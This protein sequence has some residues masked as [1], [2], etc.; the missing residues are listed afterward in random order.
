MKEKM[1]M[2]RAGRNAAL[3]QE[4]EEK[5]YV[6]VG[7]TEIGDVSGIASKSELEKLHRE[8]YKDHKPGK[9]RLDRGMLIRFRFEMKIGDD[10]LTYNP[11]A[12]DV[13]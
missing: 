2:V 1:W 6:G 5:G 4:F 9:E 12:G 8:T 13:H 10:V 3:V 11:E 7:W